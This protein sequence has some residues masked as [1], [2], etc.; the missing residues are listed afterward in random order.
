ME[1]K[2]SG[3]RR[4]LLKSGALALGAPFFSF[5]I[6]NPRKVIGPEVG[7]G[8]F[9]YRVDKTWGDQDPAR[10]P[11]NDCHEMVQDSRGRLL[12]LNNDTHNNILIYDRSG[13]VLETWGHDFPG[14]HGLTLTREGEEEFLFITCNERHQVFKTT[15]DGRV[16]MTLDYPAETGVYSKPEEYVP[17]EV[18]VAPNGDFYVADGY[19]KNYIMQY[20]H[21]GKLIRYW[22]G[23]GDADDQFDCCH[24]V[25]VDLRDPDSPSLLITSRS[26]QSFKRF[27]LD[28]KY[29]STTHL[30]GCWVCRP[31]LKG[32]NLYFAVIVTETWDNYDGC[33]A[34]LD[35]NDKVLS[36][37]GAAEPQYREGSLQPPVSDKSTFLN[38]HD[39]CVDDDE[40]L[41]IPQWNSKQTY[42]VRLVRI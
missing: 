35:R 6:Y 14:A 21:A 16:L 27:S 29:L 4:K 18:A 19:G 33:L 34:V 9:R 17:T 25:R 24:G 8:D 39:V 15:L 37:P 23:K 2:F 41:Y 31:V 38:P 28:G 30:P 13:K 20:D 22:G 36:L 7:H 3:K 26:K 5:T 11:V 40:N 32:E 1:K 10:I 42:P 12:M